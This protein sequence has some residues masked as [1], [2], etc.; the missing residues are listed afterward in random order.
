MSPSTARSAADSGRNSQPTTA[1]LMA[2]KPVN[3]INRPDSVSLNVPT[4]NNP[5]WR[6]MA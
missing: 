3:T 1:A 6:T 4:S 5:G 2:M